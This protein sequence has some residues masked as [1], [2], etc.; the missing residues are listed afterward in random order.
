[1][2]AGE[3]ELHEAVTHFRLGGSAMQLSIVH[4]HLAMLALTHGDLPAALGHTEASEVHAVQA[5]YRRG[6][7][8][9]ALLHAEIDARNSAAAARIDAR[10]GAAASALGALRR[11]LAGFKALGIEEGPICEIEGRVM[12]LLRRPVD[13]RRALAEGLRLSAA[14][15]LERGRLHTEL[16]LT[17]RDDAEPDLAAAS[18][19]QAIALFLACDA[20]RLAEAVAAR[21]APCPPVSLGR[22]AKRR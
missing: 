20:P 7:A 2:E 4:C 3:R 6:V 17:E 15:P 5:D 19:R 9:G 21:F 22:P 13:A 14:F 18:A 10:S 12:R 11:G 1:M 8:I 16:A